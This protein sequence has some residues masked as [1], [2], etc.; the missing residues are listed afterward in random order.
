MQINISKYIGYC[1]GV[2]QAIKNATTL[3]EH[4]PAQ[5]FYML[6]EI[7]H[8]QFVVNRLQDKGIK[9]VYS[10]EEIPIGSTVIIRAH[11]TTLSTYDAIRER[12]LNIVDGTC[13]FV[14]RSQNLVRDIEQKNYKLVMIGDKEHPEVQSITS[15]SKSPT[16][17]SAKEDIRKHALKDK[18][19]GVIVQSTEIVDN[20]K[21]LIGELAI[22][23]KEIWFVNTICIP[24]KKKQEEVIYLSRNNDILFI[25]G[26]NTSK[27]TNNLYLLGKKFNANTFL[28]E[29]KNMIDPNWL[30]GIKSVALASGT[31]TPPDIVI[32]ITEFLHSI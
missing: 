7:V 20:I 25:I 2:N 10:I 30:K 3:V 18:K 1:S 12:N 22:Y 4:Y 11:G 14:L 8:N 15:F 26:S 28:I 5:R 23:V 21:D 29:N 9:I 13:P 32:G 16:I 17:V 6:G 31:S 27:N 19:I 24:C